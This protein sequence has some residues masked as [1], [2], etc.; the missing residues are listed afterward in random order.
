VT[1]QSGPS[2]PQIPPGR[3]DRA[4]AARLRRNGDV[5]GAS[6]NDAQPGTFN[7]QGDR[8]GNAQR[9]MRRGDLGSASAPPAPNSATIPVQP[10]NDRRG[11]RRGVAGPRDATRSSDT[12][13]PQ[14]NARP[15]EGFRSVEPSNAPPEAGGPRNSARPYDGGGGPRASARPGGGRE[16]RAS[17]PPSDGGAPRGQRSAV[18]R[19]FEG[20]PRA[21]GGSRGS[22]VGEGGGSGG[23]SRAAPRSGPRGDAGGSRSGAS[24]GGGNRGSGNGGG[25]RGG[26]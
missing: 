17:A 8:R 15:Y 12:S 13:A 18:P 3:S 4:G 16:P 24:G 14:F 1:P 5:P 25:R 22:S 10:G 26:R 9:A 2:A 21:S 6:N 23:A 7:G 20:Q 11:D 19:G